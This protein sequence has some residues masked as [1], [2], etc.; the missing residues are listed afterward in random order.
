M[1]NNAILCGNWGTTHLRAFVLDADGRK[2]GELRGGPGIAT[3]ERGAVP[4]TLEAVLGDWLVQYPEVDVLLCGMVGSALGWFSV[5][6][7]SCPATQNDVAQGM[8]WRNALG[9]RV[10][11]VP[12]LTCNN[13]IGQTDVLRGEEV[14][15][16]GLIAQTGL[17]D[18]LVALPG[19][20]NKWVRVENGRVI[21]F[22]SIPGGEVFDALKSR[23]V[24]ARD[25]DGQFHVEAFVEGVDLI[26][27]SGPAAILPAMFATRARQVRGELDGAVSGSFLSGI[28]VG[29]DILTAQTIYGSDMQQGITLVGSPAMNAVFGR[30][31]DRLGVAWTGVDSMEA[32]AAGFHAIATRLDMTA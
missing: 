31:C 9:R 3:L 12:G 18:G 26:A 16:F 8:E 23:T 4:A 32:T 29:A 20:H 15:V 19:T 25:D 2:I 10:G 7:V 24:W 28:I 21:E 11:I 22:T 13:G 1:S 14:E 27:K 17:R 30:A 5:P 6:Y